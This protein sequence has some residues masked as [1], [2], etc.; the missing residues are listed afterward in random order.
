[1][2]TVEEMVK[3]LQDAKNDGVKFVTYGESDI[4]MP[5]PIEDAILDIQIMP[6]EMIGDGTWYPCDI[7]GNID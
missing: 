4:G 3:E 5:I 1:M 2:K 7:E 6:D